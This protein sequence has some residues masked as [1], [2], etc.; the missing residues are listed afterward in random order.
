VANEILAHQ[1]TAF[2]VPILVA[3]LTAR[4]RVTNIKRVAIWRRAVW[5]D[6]EGRTPAI[7]TGAAKEAL[8][9]G[10]EK[11]VLARIE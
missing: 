6:E 7:V 4:R 10:L 5:R 2:H 1:G 8:R 3:S 11:P 9:I